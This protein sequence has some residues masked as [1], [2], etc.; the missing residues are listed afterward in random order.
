MKHN[1]AF[2]TVACLVLTLLLGGAAPANTA[3]AQETDPQG[4]AAALA[5]ASTAFTF[6]GRLMKSGTAVDGVTCTFTFDLHAAASEGSSLETVSPTAPVSD[7]YFTAE[8]D[9]GVATFNGEARWLE[10]SVQCPGD[11]GPVPLSDKRIPLNPAPYAL[12]LRPGA[13]IDAASGNALNVKTAATSG[14][15][16]DATS[17]ATSGNA[18][19]V[20]GKSSSTSGAGLSGYNSPGG[21]GVYGSAPSGTALYGTS[22][23]GY[24]VEGN[25]SSSYGVYGVSDTSFGVRGFSTSLYGV[26]GIGGAVSVWAGHPASGVWGDSS[27][28]YG[29]HGTSDSDAGVLGRSDTGAGVWGQSASGAGV[30]G[31]SPTTGTVG[32]A[33][34][35]AGVTFGLFG[36]SN[37]SSGYG[38]YSEGNAHVEGDLT[39]KAKTSYVAIPVSAFIP[40][41]WADGYLV[42]Y[43][44][45]G[46]YL[47]N[48]SSGY[49]WYTA[50]VQ[51]PHGAVIT[52]LRV[53]YRDGSDH[54][55]WTYLRRRS[56]TAPATGAK[57]TLASVNSSGAYGSTV[58]GVRTDATVD[59][60]TI[61]N[62][63]YT[64]FLEVNLP[65]IG[66]VFHVFGVVI[67]YTITEPY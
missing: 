29:V 11:A 47:K 67:E 54:E 35:G 53:G 31:T 44:N 48:Q 61:D 32:I 21:F 51:L 3:W 25:S 57:Q 26:N 18:A 49:E 9:Y 46:D 17:S 43:D 20:Y 22:T 36:E 40:E 14:A 4:D 19:A 27:A 15:A 28:G 66:E 30:Y 50:P 65:P 39:W 45:N 55:A 58:E 37:S 64:Y 8:V 63:S 16:L 59:Y 38:V 2:A 12:S 13:T 42:E 6:Q 60:A 34:S 24:G 1:V 33:S 10:V 41:M 23:S 7:G 62:A 52:E 5:V 56:M